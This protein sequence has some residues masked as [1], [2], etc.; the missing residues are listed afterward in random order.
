MNEGR[1]RSKIL[2]VITMSGGGGATRYVYDLAT[3]LPDEFEALVVA[4]P[5]GGGAL[6]KD[7]AKAGLRT[8][9]LEHL[10]RS[11]DPRRD[12]AALRELREFFAAEKPD[13]IHLNS[14]KAGILG[15]AASRHRYRVIYTAHG[16][17][18]REQLPSHKRFL[19]AQAEKFSSRFYDQIIVLSDGDMR[20]ALALGIPGDKLT[21]IRNGIREHDFM[22]RGEARKHLSEILGFDCGERRILMTLALFFAT[23]GLNHLI[24]AVTHVNQD[25]LA[26]ILGEGMLRPQLEQQVMQ[27]GLTGRVFMPGWVPG[28]SLLLK[29]ADVYVLPSMKEG[30]PFAVLEAMQAR[31]P[32]VATRVGGVP[33]VLDHILVDPGDPAALA[34]A[35]DAQLTHP[36][37]S[38]KQPPGFQTMLDQTVACYGRSS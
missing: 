35:I 22:E 14:S 10:R 24:D 12:W 8:H 17:V 13:L 37:V 30:L 31:V 9:T 27:L 28:A 3:N 11:I 2:F 6:I 16:W 36:V 5:D 25:C 29:A 4:G 34:Q 1:P 23:K 38:D 18:F 32:I 33:E 26:V 7:A 20:A 19:Y 21:L 15:A